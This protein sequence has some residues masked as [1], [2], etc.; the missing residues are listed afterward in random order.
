MKKRILIAIVFLFGTATILMAQSNHEEL[1]PK[2]KEELSDDIGEPFVSVENMPEYKGGYDEMFK[3]IAQNIVY[4][5]AA[6]K[7]G[8]QG[9][10]F[11]YFIIDKKGKVRNAEVK[12]GIKNGEDL[13]AEALRVVKSMPAW[14]PGSQN[15]KPA[16][17]QFTV[18]VEFKL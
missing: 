9:K 17:V 18:P 3:Y 5:E 12:R 8:L 13:N 7:A 2:P 10:V 1:L 4:P 14:N 15:G 16:S 6:K 11:I